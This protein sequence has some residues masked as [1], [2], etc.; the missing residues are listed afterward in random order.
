MK[1]A[2]EIEYNSLFAIAKKHTEVNL[3]KNAQFSV[4][5][6]GTSSKRHKRRHY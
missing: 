6:M 5:K 3:T 1:S 2:Q 4:E